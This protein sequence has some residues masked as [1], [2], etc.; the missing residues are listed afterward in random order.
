MSVEPFAPLR[1]LA[2]DPEDLAVVSAALQ[3]AV[4][5]VGDI[6]FEPQARRLTIAL[7]RYRWEGDDRQRVRAALQFAGVEAVQ[8][9]R[10][11]MRAKD[12][13][14]ALLSIGFEPDATEESPGGTV[15]LTFAGGGDI[16]CRVECVEAVLADVSQPW[17]TP[18]TP[19]HEG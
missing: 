19:S 7:N 5:K 16:R 10:V 18:R 17:S 15:S 6:Q 14:L 3:D 4:V 8:A 2:Q 1:L 13:V 12:A 9:R 11:R